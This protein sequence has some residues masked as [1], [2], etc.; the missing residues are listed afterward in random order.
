MITW[1]CKKEDVC[2]IGVCDILKITAMG[3]SFDD[4]IEMIIEIQGDM[5]EDLYDCD[6]LKTFL[7]E[8][9]INVSADQVL[10]G[11][12]PFEVRVVTE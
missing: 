1:E 10:S 2:W 6:E 9:N 7:L 12:V 4:L 3:E 11:D 5:L 8:R